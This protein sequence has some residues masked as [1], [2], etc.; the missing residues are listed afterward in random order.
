MKNQI[1]ALVVGIS[2][3]LFSCLQAQITFERWY[4]GTSWD[5]GYS[6]AQTSDGGY[7]VAGW[8]ESYGAGSEDV[9][10][11]K[12]DAQGI[13]GI[14]EKPDLRHKTK[15]IR[16][17]CYPNPFTTVTR[18]EVLGINK[19]QK[20]NLNIYDASGRLVKSAKLETSTYQ[21]GA[22][23]LPGIYFLKVDGRYVGKVVKVK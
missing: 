22:D 18:F 8:T 3:L 15:N 21:L 7:I 23:L 14:Q 9:Y 4:G 6:V 5:G 13:I 2:L 20:V 12:T 19:T 11:I 10:L 17:H 1:I 16:L